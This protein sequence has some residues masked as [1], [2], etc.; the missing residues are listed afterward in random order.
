[1]TTA[2]MMHPGPSHDQVDADLINQVGRYN[3]ESAPYH[4]Q[5]IEHFPDYR[6][7]YNGSGVYVSH[8]VILVTHLLNDH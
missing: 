7:D 2:A 3:A 8:R 4:Q 1:M 5:A 6:E